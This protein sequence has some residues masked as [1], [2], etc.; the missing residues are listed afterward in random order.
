MLF[1][2]W[3]APMIRNFAFVAPSFLFGPFFV[4]EEWLRPQRACAAPLAK[5][6][7]GLNGNGGGADGDEGDREAVPT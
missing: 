3:K 5:A 2:Y 7:Q 6:G 4:A 1:T